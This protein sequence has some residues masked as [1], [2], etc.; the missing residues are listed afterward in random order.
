MQT[1]KIVPWLWF[2]N[3]LQEA[4]DFYISAFNN[5]S[6]KEME[7]MPDGKLLVGSF[8]IRGREIYGMDAGP[9]FKFNPSISFY[10]NCASEQELDLLWNKLSEGET[11][12]MEYQKYDFAEKYGWLQDKFGVSWQLILGGEKQLLAPLL[13]FANQNFGRAQEAMDFYTRIFPNSSIDSVSKYQDE[14]NSDKINHAEF[15]LCGLDFMAMDALGEHKF[16][17][18]EAISFCIDCEDQ[19]EVDKYWRELT[20]DGGKESVCGWVYD[21]FGVCWQVTPKRLNELMS[22]PDKEKANRVMQC[23]LGQKKI[24]IEE[25][26][27]AYKG[28]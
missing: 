8:I 13:M 15:K 14:A 4:S 2:D 28:E 7:T 21:K 18:N 25:L 11:I 5:A 12:L 26:E 24:I 16:G 6:I 20:A 22:D 9:E 1:Q 3:K 19:E 23:M 27:K 17:F 10:V